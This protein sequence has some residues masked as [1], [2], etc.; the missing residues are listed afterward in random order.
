MEERNSKKKTRKLLI[1]FVFGE[2]DF[3]GL[4]TKSFTNELSEF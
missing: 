3:F 2:E 1:G 4:K